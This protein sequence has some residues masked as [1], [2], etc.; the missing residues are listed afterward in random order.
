MKRVDLYERK[1]CH[2]IP[3]VFDN[4]FTSVMWPIMWGI[5]NSDITL[6]WHGNVSLQGWSRLQKYTEESSRNSRSIFSFIPFLT[7][8]H[9]PRSKVVKLLQLLRIQ[10]AP[11]DVRLKQPKHSKL[12]RL[13]TIITDCISS[14]FSCWICFRKHIKFTFS[15]I[16]PHWIDVGSWN[17]CKKHLVRFFIFL[18]TS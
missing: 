9:W 15:I 13:K 10:N 8:Q 11:R 6:L 3:I 16:S 18:V 5:S 7:F 4:Y 2:S 1:S 12:L 14:L 17:N